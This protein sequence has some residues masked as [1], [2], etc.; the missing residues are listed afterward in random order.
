MRFLAICLLLLVSLTSSAQSESFKNYLLSQQLISPSQLEHHNQF[1]KDLLK[2]YEAGAKQRIKTQSDSLRVET[3]ATLEK[4][5]KDPLGVFFFWDEKDTLGSINTLLLRYAGGGSVEFE[6]GELFWG[7]TD[8]AKLSPTDS[9]Q[10]KSYIQLLAK[11]RLISKFTVRDLVKKV[12]ENLITDTATVIMIASYL[13]QREKEYNPSE[14]SSYLDLL[15]AKDILIKGE[16]E[17]LQ[18]LANDY[19]LEA[20]QIFDACKRGLVLKPSDFDG[21]P[22]DLIPGLYEKVKAVLPDL[23]ITALKVR[24]DTSFRDGRR[25][26]EVVVNLLANK[27]HYIQRNSYSP[28]IDFNGDGKSDI[29]LRATDYFSNVFN[30]ILID[31]QSSYRL[32]TVYTDGTIE[33]SGKLYLLAASYDQATSIY[34]SGV[35]MVKPY[36]D[37]Y[38]QKPIS[39]RR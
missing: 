1:L 16:K 24:I 27:K 13:K 9:N 22:R 35:L 38:V 20:I 33:S 2:Q 19:N 17:K 25:I 15:E 32:V 18:L 11:E 14:M 6:N 23:K 37:L 8:T 10:L 21:E 26:Y 30:K 12:R 36:L 39:N 31:Q 28:L 4:A 5:K 29:K 7:S 34:K 3:L